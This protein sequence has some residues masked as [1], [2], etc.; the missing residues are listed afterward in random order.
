M[1]TDRSAGF[2]PLTRVSN[3]ADGRDIREEPQRTGGAPLLMEPNGIN[4]TRENNDFL[5]SAEAFGRAVRVLMHGSALA[6]RLANPGR[7]CVGWNP[8]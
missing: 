5:A 7:N 6:Q 3:F 8:R 4:T 1:H 2:F